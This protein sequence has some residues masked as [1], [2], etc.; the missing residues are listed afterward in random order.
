[1]EPKVFDHL[2]LFGTYK[3]DPPSVTYE[4]F[5]IYYD[6]NGNFIHK[7][8]TENLSTINLNKGILYERQESR[9]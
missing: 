2:K 7:T 9:D 1:M 5:I 4:C 3:F 6:E 8:P